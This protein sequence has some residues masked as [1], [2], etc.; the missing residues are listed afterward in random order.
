M[1]R[2]KHGEKKRCKIQKKNMSHVEHGENM[3][4]RIII[5]VPEREE[6]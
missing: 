1:K 6:N 3:E 5:G 4:H 2:L